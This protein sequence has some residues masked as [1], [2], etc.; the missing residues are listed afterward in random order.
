MVYRSWSDGL[1]QLK[2]STNVHLP[3]PRLRSARLLRLFAASARSRSLSLSSL[4]RWLRAA[5]PRGA[6][7]PPLFSPSESPAWDSASD[8]SDDRSDA[9]RCRLASLLALVVKLVSSVYPAQVCGSGKL[10]PRFHLYLSSSSSFHCRVPTRHLLS[11]FVQ[12]LRAILPLHR[13]L[14]DCS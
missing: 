3:S 1:H 11:Y 9:V 4:S 6:C 5:A 14:S 12:A 8:L 7:F 13:R 10:T 2:S